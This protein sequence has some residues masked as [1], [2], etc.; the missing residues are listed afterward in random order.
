M[1]I[2]KRQHNGAYPSLLDRFFNDEWKFGSQSVFNNNWVPATNIRELENGYDIE[3]SVPG[4][5]KEDLG[6]EI[7]NG[8]MVISGNHTVDTESEE[9]QYKRREFNHSSFQ[10]TFKLPDGVTEKEISAKYE[11]G[12]LNI[13]LEKKSSWFNKSNSIKI[14]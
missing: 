3:L 1:D 7:T 8:T 2:I 5:K 14:K 6:I 10:R 11:N 9:G 12:I 4:F 13:R